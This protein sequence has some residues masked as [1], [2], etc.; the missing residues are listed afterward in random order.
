MSP[1]L[2][3]AATFLLL[4]GLDENAARAGAS[5]PRPPISGPVWPCR[6][7]SL[8]LPGGGGTPPPLYCAACAYLPEGLLHGAAREASN[9]R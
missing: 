9:D 1:P 6:K 8:D 2:S 5:L 3:C 4:E 7:A